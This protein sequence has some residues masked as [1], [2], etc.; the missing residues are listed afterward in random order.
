MVKLAFVFML[1]NALFYAVSFFAKR[2]V[3]LLLL[4]I[5][6]NIFFCLQYLVVKAN[7]GAIVIAVDTL[8]LIAF[9]FVEKF[10]N[11]NP[12]RISVGLIFIVVSIVC[13]ALTWDKWFSVLPL[14]STVSITASLMVNK[15][16][17]VKVVSMLAN[18]LQ[19][20]YM[21]FIKSYLNLIID[22]CVVTA[23]TIAVIIDLRRLKKRK[24]A[25]AGA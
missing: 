12:M 23:S 4:Q 9:Y 10:K 21:I 22:A 2:K 7:T 14:L 3:T 1:I 5:F 18:P 8:R 13:A 16:I 6:S 17:V 20:V 24:Q 19:L 11:T 15:L 25:P